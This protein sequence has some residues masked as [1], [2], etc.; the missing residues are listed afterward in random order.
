MLLVYKRK[1]WL[2][3]DGVLLPGYVAKHK[4]YP[5]D[6]EC[7]F[8]Y[9]RIRKKDTGKSLFYDKQEAM[10]KTGLQVCR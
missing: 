3:D 8:S 2:M 10:S 1:A 9:Q 7:G 6:F 5:Y 4:F